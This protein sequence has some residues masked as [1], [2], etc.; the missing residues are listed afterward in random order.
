MPGPFTSPVARSVP[1]DNT[2]TNLLVAENEQDAIDE[3]TSQQNIV[4]LV[5]NA[6]YNGS[7]TNNSFLGRDNLLPNTPMTFA[8]NVQINEL[9]FVN[10]NT[11]A[12]FFLDLYKNGQSA[13]N[14]IQTLS[15]TT[16]S[17]K[18]QVFSGLT[19]NFN[20]GDFLFFR[21]RKISGSTPSDSSIDIYCKVTG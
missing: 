19:L 1:F 8:R 17:S 16:G 2:V 4:R 6:T 3:L 14:L 9:A 5:L 13:G 15:F 12:A 21:Y 11:N 10:Q 7:W 20:A 18:L